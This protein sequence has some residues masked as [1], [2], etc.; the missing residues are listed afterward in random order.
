MQIETFKLERNQSLYENTVDFNLTESGVH[1]FKLYELLDQGEREALLNIELGYGQTNGSEKLRARI[2]DLY[3]GLSVDNV[4]VTNGSSEANFVAVWSL[5]EAGDEII[6]MQPNYMQIAGLAKSMG[7]KVVPLKLYEKRHWSPDLSELDALTTP[8]TRMI[9]ICNPNNPTGSVLGKED[10]VTLIAHCQTHDLI[11]YADEVYRGAELQGPVTPSVL[12]LYAKSI[13]VGGMSK[14]MSAAGLRIG[15]IASS[16]AVVDVAW[17]HRDYTSICCS[18]LSQFVAEKILHKQALVK[19]RTRAQKYLNGNLALV[20][21]WVEQHNNNFSFIAPQAGG[22]ILLKY[23]LPVSSKMLTKILRQE[24]SIL[25]VAGDDYNLG[26]YLRIGIG[27]ES[28][29]L[30][31]GLARLHTALGT[32]CSN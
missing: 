28:A 10:M 26:K 14:S 25:V 15:W 16:E 1:P 20:A 21:S 19:I 8:K 17:K 4:L 3:S 23:N 22:M 12:D 9:C 5:L 29:Y 18:V 30:A 31:D 6:Y 27:G 13:V 24:H 11:L 7:V 32:I 2:A